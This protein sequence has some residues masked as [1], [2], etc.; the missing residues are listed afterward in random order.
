M[1]TLEEAFDYSELTATA[2][3]KA[4]SKVVS[5]ARS[6]AKAA[7]TGNI[8]AIKR[9]QQNMEEALAALQQEVTEAVACWPF[10]DEEEQ[11]IFNDRFAED[12]MHY[13]E[14][15]ELSIYEQDGALI[16]YPSIVRLLPA[17]CAVKID[18]KKVSAIRLS[19]LVDLLIKNQRKSSSFAAA[20]LLESMYNVYKDI[21]GKSSSGSGSGVSSPVVPLA[22]IY[23]LLTSLPGVA[24]EYDR[25]DFARDLYTL[26]IDGPRNTR[27][28]AI[29]S[30]PSSTGTRR[31]SSDVF[32]FIGPDGNRVEYYGVQFT[33]A[34]Q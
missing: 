5:S 26:E 30:F 11:K 21:T 24:R 1:K 6:M 22:R 3:Q 34:K 13:A 9:Y 32:S 33:E 23:K 2:V 31:R 20:R 8:N 17:D 28:G 14:E 27:R 4:A 10:S 25:S 15:N 16:S 29:V 7:K 18:R 12:L 19:F